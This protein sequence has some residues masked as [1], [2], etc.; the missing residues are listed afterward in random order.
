MDKPLRKNRL[1]QVSS[2]LNLTVL[3]PIGITA[4]LIA[5]GVSPLIAAVAGGA[6]ALV[7][8]LLMLAYLLGFRDRGTQ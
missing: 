5:F 6:C 4:G 3:L 2:I 8:V 7:A 1:E